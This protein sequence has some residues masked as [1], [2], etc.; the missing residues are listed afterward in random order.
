MAP[1]FLRDLEYPRNHPEIWQGRKRRGRKP[2]SGSNDQ[3]GTYHK[4]TTSQNPMKNQ[5]QPSATKRLERFRQSHSYAS[6]TEIF[7]H[8]EYGKKN[9]PFQHLGKKFDQL[10]WKSY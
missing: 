8:M 10:V 9:S 3:K 7:V 5:I 1:P 6:N 2:P 4:K